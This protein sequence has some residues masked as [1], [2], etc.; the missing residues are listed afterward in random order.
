MRYLDEL[1]RTTDGWRIRRRHATV[2]WQQ[3]E[4]PRA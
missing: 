2:E 1:V 4:P 3:A